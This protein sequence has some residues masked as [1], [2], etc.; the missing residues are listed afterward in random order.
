MALFVIW[1]QSDELDLRHTMKDEV[2]LINHKLAKT[3]RDIRDNEGYTIRAFADKTGM[4]HSFVG[5]I[6]SELRRLDVGEFILY[7][8]SLNR[9]PAE[10]LQEITDDRPSGPHEG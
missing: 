1:N 6:E 5:K 7:C 9:D 4:P 8:L 3:L 10:V 2:K